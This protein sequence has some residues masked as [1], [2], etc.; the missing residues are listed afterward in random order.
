RACEAVKARLPADVSVM[1]LAAFQGAEHRWGQL[2]AEAGRAAA[3][4]ITR[5]VE[6]AMAGE[7]AAVVTAPINKEALRLAG[8]P[9]PGHTEMLAAL[10]GTRE[11]A[12]MLAGPT[13]RV[14]H[15]TGHVSL[16]EAIRRV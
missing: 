14:A 16:E 13:L 15:V 8:V 11:Y 5:A 6:M 9:Y 2:S 3:A 10:T 4:Y 1:D 12:M 7:V